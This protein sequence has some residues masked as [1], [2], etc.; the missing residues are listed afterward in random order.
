MTT[1][2]SLL[3]LTALVLALTTVLS[4][5][6]ERQA[7][8]WN[9]G[10]GQSV[11]FVDG[12]PRLSPASAVEAFE[13]VVSMSDTAGNLLFYTNGGGRPAN[14]A[15]PAEL[16]PSPGIIW[17]REGGVLYDMR[18]E[19]G[20]GFS[21]RQSAIAFP[22]PAGEAGVYYLFTMEEA[23]FDTGGSVAGQPQGRG[24][25]YFVL[26]MALNGGLGG[27]R[28]A[29]QRVYVPAYEALNVTPMAEEAGFWVITH[30]NDAEDP[31]FV[32]VPVTAAGVGTPVET[33]TDRVQGRI[34]FSP[35]GQY[36]INDGRL[37]GFDNGSG[38]IA[39][40]PVELP[41]IS[42]QAVCFTPDSRFF[43]TIQSDPGLGDVIVRYNAVTLEVLQVELVAQP[44]ATSNLVVGNFQLAPNG[45]IYFLEESFSPSGNRYGLSEIRCVGNPAPVVSRFLLDLEQRGDFN[46]QTLPNYVDAIF[47]DLA[48]ADTVRLDTLDL[49]SC[50][51]NNGSGA[52]R[53][54][55]RVTGTAYAWSTGATTETIFAPEP[56]VYCVTITNECNVTVDCQEISAPEIILVDIFED[57]C[58]PNEYSYR[59]DF[60]QPFLFI[61]YVLIESN[62]PADI[63]FEGRT[64][65]NVITVTAPEEPGS[66][67]IQ[68]EVFNQRACPSN[69]VFLSFDIPEVSQLDF[70]PFIDLPDG[71]STPCLNQP[72]E[73]E[74]ANNSDL[75]IR[76]VIYPDGSTNNPGT[77]TVSTMEPFPILVVSECGDTTE[78]LYDL[79]ILEFCACEGEVPEL[80]TPNGDG[81]NDDFRLFSTTGC[82]VLD[83][84]LVVYNR[85]GQPIFRSSNP[86]QAWDGTIDGTPQPTDVYLF[87]MAYRFPQDATVRIEEGQLNLIR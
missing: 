41:L 1:D 40:D 38:A 23:E 58:G 9:F 63:L 52:V 6:P 82:P 10:F 33:S 46:A 8:N 50:L 7:A 35:N 36:M 2:L 78:L 83:Y 28:T 64:E 65:D 21:A 66:Y 55:A 74:V 26:D 11:S 71:A 47:Q 72:F 86:N 17:N 44:G 4:A 18:G 75:E 84:N 37:F 42:T 49:N 24:L 59:I 67:T 27:V 19:E 43:Y 12:Q 14:G 29:D 25:S 77:V 45:N 5:Q 62:T 76:E 85:W 57:R 32:V 68:V 48:L 3:R 56:G 16:Q 34:E 70:S 73:V 61:N 79:P 69:I 39:S 22:D 31:K 30:S 80:M 60:T 13:G 53:L 51:S 20:G 15:L 87:R 54:T 81:S